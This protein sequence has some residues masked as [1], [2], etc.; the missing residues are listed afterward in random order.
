MHSIKHRPSVG[1][2][3]FLMFCGKVRRLRAS[4]RVPGEPQQQTVH[5]GG[6]NTCQVCPT[7][8]SGC[9]SCYRSGTINFSCDVNL[10]MLDQRC[11]GGETQHAHVQTAVPKSKPLPGVTAA[12]ATWT[13]TPPNRVRYVGPPM[14]P[15]IDMIIPFLSSGSGSSSG[16]LGKAVAPANRRLCRRRGRGWAARVS[17]CPAEWRSAQAAPTKKTWRWR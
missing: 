2:P 9:W 10:S 14:T 17:H 6:V 1:T 5:H 11:L 4:R 13:A 8:T 12:A 7:Q 3:G 15:E 16:Q